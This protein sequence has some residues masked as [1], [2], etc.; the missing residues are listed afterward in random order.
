[1]SVSQR[2]ADVVIHLT[3]KIIDLTREPFY[4]RELPG[5]PTQILLGLPEAPRRR[6]VRRRRR[7]S[8]SSDINRRRRWRSDVDVL[9]IT[10]IAFVAAIAL[11]IL[12]VVV[13]FRH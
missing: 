3:D 8:S 12:T 4:E 1:M 10:A 13:T 6:P 9:T 7:R 2:D 11:V 5:P